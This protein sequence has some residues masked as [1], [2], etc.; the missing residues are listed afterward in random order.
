VHN[1][2]ALVE[3]VEV[4]EMSKEGSEAWDAAV[5]R[6]NERVDSVE[7]RI[8]A[9]LREQLA[10]AKSANEMFRIFARYLLRD[11]DPGLHLIMIYIRVPITCILYLLNSFRFNALFVRP[12]IRG[13]IREYQTQLIQRVK[14]DIDTLH[15]KFKVPIYIKVK[16][17]EFLVH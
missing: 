4:L 8:T 15:E 14:D 10:T 3:E 16:G 9:A 7:A 12:Q 2:Y 6:Y 13:A 11:P 5:K 1:A 17:L